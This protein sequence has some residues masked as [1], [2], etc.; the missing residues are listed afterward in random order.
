MSNISI[1][2]KWG[3]TIT[4]DQMKNIYKNGIGPWFKMIDGILYLYAI[5]I[6]KTLELELYVSHILSKLKNSSNKDEKKM[7]K[8]YETLDVYMT[9]SERIV[10]TPQRYGHQYQKPDWICTIRMG[11]S[12][13]NERKK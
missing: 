3:T 12:I 10:K 6:D 7:Y 4:L 9:N 5:K 13:I 1:T 11:D 8:K 2:T